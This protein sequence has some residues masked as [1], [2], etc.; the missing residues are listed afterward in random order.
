MTMSDANKIIGLIPKPIEPV[1]EPAEDVLH[2]LPDQ[3]HDWV[4]EE[5]GSID[6]FY[7]DSNEHNGPGCIKCEF[8]FCHHCHQGKD[9]PLGYGNKDCLREQARMRNIERESKYLDAK[10]TFRSE[11]SYYERI[12]EHIRAAYADTPQ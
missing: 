1:R 10:R 3:G 2:G 12:V 11:M 8:S 5:N 9:N 4:R 7:V 6:I